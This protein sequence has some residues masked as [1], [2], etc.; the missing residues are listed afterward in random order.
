MP[1]KDENLVN[2]DFADLLHE[3]NAGGVEYV[4]VGGQ[5]FGFHAQPRYTKDIDVLVRPNPEN[6]QRVYRALAAFGA[7][8]DDLSVQDLTDADIVF[9]IGIEPN[10]IDVLTAIDGVTFDGAWASRVEGS[11]GGERMWVIGMDDLI[12]SKRAA[13]RERDLLDVRE[14]E[15]RRARG[16]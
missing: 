1:R 14:L 5:A 10:R 12:A 2:S 11:H 7:P 15:R 6:A 8:L 9:Q 16:K 4:I 13:G 3:F